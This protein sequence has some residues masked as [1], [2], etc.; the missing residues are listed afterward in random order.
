MENL[1][2]QMMRKLYKI[3]K[4]YKGDPVTPTLNE[5]MTGPYKAEFMHKTTQ[6]IKELEQ[7]GTWTIVYSKS[8]TS[9]HIL[10]ITWDFT[11]K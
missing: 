10:P 7:H 4:L 9:S 1:M 11:V 8:V 2:P 3:L 5:A 6:D